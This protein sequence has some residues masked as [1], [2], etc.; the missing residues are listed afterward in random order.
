MIGCSLVEHLYGI[1]YCPAH[2]AEAHDDRDAYFDYHKVVPMSLAH[3]FSELD[4]LLKML[5][6]PFLVRGKPGWKVDYGYTLRETFIRYDAAL[7]DWSIPIIYADNDRSMHIPLSE[8]A[9]RSF[10]SNIIDSARSA[11]NVGVFV[12]LKPLATE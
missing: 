8:F 6:A 9:E 1:Y 3:Q 12:K 5:E 4:V 2:E 11:L 7:K 10:D